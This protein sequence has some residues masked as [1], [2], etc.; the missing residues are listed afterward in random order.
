MLSSRSMRN[1]KTNGQLF[2]SATDLSRHLACSHLT[3]LRRAVAFGLREP[4]RPYNDPR[5]EV[6]RQRGLEHEQG[7]LDQ[8]ATDGRTVETIVPVETRV[9]HGDPVA[10]AA[11]TRDAMRRGAEVIYQGR[12]EDDGGRWSGYPDFL[13]RVDRPS[14]LGGW[15]YEVLD[16]KLARRAKGGALLQLLLYSD[17]LAQAQGIEPE[18][19]HLALGGGTSESPASFRVAEYAAYYRAVRQRFEAHATSP[20]DTYPEPVEHCGVSEWQQACAARR[21]ADDHLS[22]VASI[23]RRQRARLVERAVTRLAAL[24]A[25]YLPVS[26]RL[27]GIGEAA[28]ARIREQARVQ[29]QGR[30]EGRRIHELVTPL[31]VD[32]G[33]AALPEPSVGDTSTTTAPTR[34]PPSS[35]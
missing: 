25:L 22:L 9:S 27:D 6:L 2:F 15:S 32:K 35:A 8:F 21:R 30:Q 7:L 4:P 23:T 1:A 19:M 17:L 16:A 28:L 31:E 24:A 12:L 3:S 5:A 20:P 13:F 18:L 33:L 29:D 26:P 34:P 14:A 10:A 11:G